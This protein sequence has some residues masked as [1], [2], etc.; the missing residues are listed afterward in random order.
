MQS[1]E[2]TAVVTG[3]ADGLGLLL[4]SFLLAAGWHV[5]GWSTEE[6]FTLPPAAQP[7]D[8][9]FTYQQ[10]DVQWW[11]DICAA[12]ASIDPEIRVD[13]LVNCTSARYPRPFEAI[14]FR[15][16]E[17][18]LDV[19]AKALAMTTRAL[20]PAMANPSDPM[21][22]GTVCNVIGS[23]ARVPGYHLLAYS[24]SKAAAL[25]VTRQMAH[26]LFQSHG[27]TVFSVSPN[28]GEGP[29]G[30]DI[31]PGMLAEFIGFLL[32]KKERHLYLHGSDLP[33]GG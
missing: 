30:L 18:Q 33:Y 20:L 22:A 14:D 5:I 21:S 16:W 1:D 29:P 8:D 23:S 27:L 7:F 24:A 31:D 15:E 3:C 6:E 13:A 11:D 26:E 17:H 25:M 12:V 10:V 32:S 9:Q 19:N 28:E 4:T 2:H